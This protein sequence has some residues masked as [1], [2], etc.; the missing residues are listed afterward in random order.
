VATYGFEVKCFGRPIHAVVGYRALYVDYSD[1]G[2][3]GE[4]G[5]NGVQHGPIMGATMRW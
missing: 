2:R 3:F 1:T 5:I 4:A